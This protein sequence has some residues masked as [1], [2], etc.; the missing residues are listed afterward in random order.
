MHNLQLSTEEVEALRE[1]L[2]HLVADMGVEVSR[3]DTREYKEM[4]KHRR[5]LL[6]RVLDR[7]NTVPVTA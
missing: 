7:L 3:T 2:S 1:V 4:L 6:E 5:E